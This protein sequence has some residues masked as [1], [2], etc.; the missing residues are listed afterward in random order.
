MMVTFAPGI[1]NS[2]QNEFYAEVVFQFPSGSFSALL[3]VSVVAVQIAGLGD[4]HSLE[5]LAGGV[6]LISFGSFWLINHF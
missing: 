1:F 4:R 3:H 2:Y 5:S 6:A